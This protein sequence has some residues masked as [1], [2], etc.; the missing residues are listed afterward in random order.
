[1]I[2][3]RVD[4]D[5]L[6]RTRLSFSPALETFT[7][8]R[9]AAA[10]KRHPV[11]GD[12]GPRARAALARPDVALLVSL[13]PPAGSTYA[14]DLLTPMPGVNASV[15]DVFDEQLAMIESMDED[16]VDWQICRGAEL[17]WGVPVSAF[18]RQAVEFGRIRSR[19]AAGLVEFWRE[20]V[21]DVWPVLRSVLERDLVDRASRLASHGLAHVLGA[22]HPSFTWVGD[23]L[24][25]DKPWTHSI[26][27]TGGQ[28]TLA[29]A[30]LTWPDAFIQVDTPGQAVLYFPASRVGSGTPRSSGQLASVL[31]SARS[32]ILE[33]LTVGRSTAELSARLGYVP[34]TI[35]YHLGAMHRAGLV[36]K[37]RDGRY[38]LYQ[39]TPQGQLLLSSE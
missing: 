16:L 19:L 1:M 32:A 8:L 38:V 9:L 30:V 17:Y 26:D 28:L 10:G 11:F 33:E 2:T 12:P 25:L 24:V 3:L 7:W 4:A 34:G 36:T 29:P 21:A 39:R 13:L 20:A 23:G 6:A 5:V 18:V 37:V 15:T 31:G 27:L 22:L 35:S 14:A